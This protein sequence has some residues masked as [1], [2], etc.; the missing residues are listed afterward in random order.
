MTMTSFMAMKELHV[1]FWLL[2]GGILGAFC[3]LI[4]KT[5]FM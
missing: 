3:A 4:S 1:A 5:D 2:S